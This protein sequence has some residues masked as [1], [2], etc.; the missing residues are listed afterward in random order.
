LEEKRS[1]AADGGCHPDGI[2]PPSDLLEVSGEHRQND[3]DRLSLKK[4]CG[5]EAENA[6]AGAS[7]PWNGA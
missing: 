6:A 1:Q 7:L 5:I 3:T 4:I 2:E